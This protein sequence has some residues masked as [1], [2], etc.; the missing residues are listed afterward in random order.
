[1][2]ELW[3]RRSGEWNFVG[4]YHT[5]RQADLIAADYRSRGEIVK[6]VHE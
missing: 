4:A 6:I 5:R 2:Y 1:M 3:A